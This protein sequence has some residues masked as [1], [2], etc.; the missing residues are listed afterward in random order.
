MNGVFRNAYIN[1]VQ[2]MKVLASAVLSLFL[3][4]GHADIII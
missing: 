3:A 2:K 4:F 1:H